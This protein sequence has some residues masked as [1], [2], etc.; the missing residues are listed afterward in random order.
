MF[1]MLFGMLACLLNA[2]YVKIGANECK[3]ML[4]YTSLFPPTRRVT[5][6]LV[7]QS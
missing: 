5:L 6:N 7:K 1:F 2:A 4:R 3:C